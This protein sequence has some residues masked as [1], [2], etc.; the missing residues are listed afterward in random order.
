MDLKEYSDVEVR[1]DEQL[2]ASQHEQATLTRRATFRRREWIAMV[3]VAILAIWIL[4]A[5]SQRSRRSRYQSGC[6]S[7]QGR[8]GEGLLMFAANHKGRLPSVGK[9][10]QGWLTGSAPVV[11]SNSQGLLVLLAKGYV[12][13]T[14]IFRCPAAGGQGFVYT[15]A[16]TEF[17]PG[18]V[19]G[20]SYQYSLGGGLHLGD[21]RGDWMVA[22]VPVLADSSPLFDSGT[23]DAT[24]IGRN[25]RNHDRD[26]QNVLYLSGDVRWART[27]RAGIADNDIYTVDATAT[28][29]G[30]ETPANSED[31]FLL[32]AMPQ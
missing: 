30:T 14:H 8:L 20:Y 13:D 9:R 26:G 31:T 16:L 3:A 12:N 27:S 17:P 18:A 10:G 5:A 4:I 29:R 11:A 22:A 21:E 1:R 7:H 19:V 24:Q 2:L 6:A 28:Y 23:F 25:S 32:P 15:S